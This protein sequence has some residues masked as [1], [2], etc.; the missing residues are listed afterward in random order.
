MLGYDRFARDDSSGVTTSLALT[1]GG[2]L[3]CSCRTSIQDMWLRGRMGI[4]L[5]VSTHARGRS[6]LQRAQVGI[7]RT[8]WRLRGRRV[9]PLRS[10]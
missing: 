2:V 3:V 1:T 6:N 4:D 10:R 7:A 9:R 5:P 8:Q